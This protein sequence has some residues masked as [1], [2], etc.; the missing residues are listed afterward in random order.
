VAH[1][2]RLARHD[3]QSAFSERHGGGFHRLGRC[4]AICYSVENDFWLEAYPL[5]INAVFY[6]KTLDYLVDNQ[7]FVVFKFISLAL[8]LF[9]QFFQFLIHF[10]K[11]FFC[12]IVKAFFEKRHKYAFKFFTL[13][14]R[15]CAIAVVN[16]FKFMFTIK[17]SCKQ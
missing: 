4:L 16:E 11:P 2:C 17:E 8:W 7:A 10:F 3:E 9:S 1:F 15:C 12:I 14:K 13:L 5:S 6:A